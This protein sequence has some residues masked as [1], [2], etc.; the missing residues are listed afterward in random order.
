MA[1][2]EHIPQQPEHVS[3]QELL[4]TFARFAE[5]IPTH[6]HTRDPQT[7]RDILAPIT[8]VELDPAAMIDDVRTAT[9]TPFNEVE[10]I[11]VSH[12]APDYDI[13]GE[14]GGTMY[15]EVI[16]ITMHGYYGDIDV[17]ERSIS[18]VIAPNEETGEMN[19]FV[20][21]NF[22]NADSY[23]FADPESNPKDFVYVQ[24]TE[25]LRTIAADLDEYRAFIDEGIAFA[26]PGM[27]G[28][29]KRTAELRPLDMNDM[30]LFDSAFEQL[31]PTPDMPI[32]A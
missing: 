32:E 8:P 30:L 16:A 2:H 25:L 20:V 27:N 14:R 29:V 1:Q 7:G 4:E 9:D 31:A 12:L 3:Q 19:G 26:T 11:V 10:S 28:D 13:H 21:Q 5:A 18:Y 15:P 6:M 17:S 22:H 24:P 23:S